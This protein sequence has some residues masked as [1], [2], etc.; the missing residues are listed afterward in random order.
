[1]KNLLIAMLVIFNLS[2]ALAEE[3][4]LPIPGGDETGTVEPLPEPPPPSEEWPQEP[5][6]LPPEQTPQEPP[7]EQ[8]PEPV[9][10][11]PSSG[12]PG[13]DT[14]DRVS[15]GDRALVVNGGM[16]LT[17]NVV[18]ISRD[19]K[20]I[21]LRSDYNGNISTYK[22]KQVGIWLRCS[23]KGLC[24]GHKAMYESNRGRNYNP[25]TVLA[26][27]SNN[28]SLVTDD[29]TGRKFVLSNKEILK[30][31]GCNRKTA[32][33]RGQTVLSE[34]MGS[35]PYFEAQVLEVYEGGIYLISNYNGGKDIRKNGDLAQQVG[36]Y[37]KLCVG[38]QL[39]F[40]NILRVYENGFFV[41]QDP[42]SGNLTLRPYREIR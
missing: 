9:P 38:Q 29:F 18:S 15:I 12:Q 37:K 25:V 33:C 21:T 35:A 31:E 5:Q 24:A 42:Y 11:P 20:L 23:S 14:D 39:Y 27:Y 2:H 7:A 30:A 3:A 17:G 32:I 1:M 10:Q 13:A 4:D 16:F 8:N 36:C 22:S 6:P 41:I 34:A 19:G 40:G 26:T 28:W